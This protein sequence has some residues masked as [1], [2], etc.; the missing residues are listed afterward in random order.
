M[1]RL[2]NQKPSYDS[3][4][5]PGPPQLSS[6]NGM[7]PFKQLDSGHLAPGIE[8]RASVLGCEVALT[9]VLG[10]LAGPTWFALVWSGLLLADDER[11]GQVLLAFSLLL[12]L[13]RAWRGVACAAFRP[14]CVCLSMQQQ[15]GEYGGIILWLAH[16]FLGSRPLCSIER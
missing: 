11:Y 7:L 9:Q 12:W 5:S 15:G 16:Y 1:P 10:N 8:H 2:R 4:T 13:L 6:S 14:D 3:V